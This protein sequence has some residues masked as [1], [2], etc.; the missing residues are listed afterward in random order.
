M[1]SVKE[2]PVQMDIS[3]KLLMEKQKEFSIE[4]HISFIDFIKEFDNI[5]QNKLF[6]IVIEDGI[7]IQ[8]ICPIFNGH[9]SSVISVKILF[10]DLEANKSRSKTKIPIITFTF[11]H[12]CEFLIIRIAAT[13]NRSITVNQ[14]LSL[15]VQAFVGDVVFL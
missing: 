10:I 8:I 15:D 2:D 9:L 5:D 1:D 13:N 7:P 14:N 11:Q 4:I 3:F 6:E 12:I